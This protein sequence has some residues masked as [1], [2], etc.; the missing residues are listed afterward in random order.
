MMLFPLLCF[1]LNCGRIK[2]EMRS[3]ATDDSMGCALQG[4]RPGAHKA[5]TE[6]LPVPPHIAKG[7]HCTL[8]GMLAAPSLHGISWSFYIWKET[9]AKSLDMSLF[10]K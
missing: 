10:G 4:S 2:T 1:A 5:T 7:L 6:K 8:P 3:I 9:C